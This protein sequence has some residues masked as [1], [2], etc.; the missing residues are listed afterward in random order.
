M[1]VQN[2]HAFSKLFKPKSNQSSPKSKEIAN[3]KV[4]I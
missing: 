1:N 4:D 3:L 2:L